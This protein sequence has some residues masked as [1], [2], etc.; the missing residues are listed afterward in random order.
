MGQAWTA[1]DVTSTKGKQDENFPVGSWL[2]SKRNRSDVHAYYNFAR[3]SDDISDTSELTNEQKL[4]RLGSMAAI[5][6]GE[7]KAPQRYDAHTAEVLRDVLI[8]RSVP[9]ETATDLLHAFSMDVKKNRYATWEELLHYCQYS[10]NPVGRF[11]LLLHGENK[12]TLPASDALCTA[13]QVINHLQDA[14]KD[15]KFLDR[16]YVPSSWMEEEGVT[17]DDLRL[18][19]SKPGIRRVFDRMLDEVDRLNRQASTLPMLIR[20]RHMRLEASVI[21]KLSCLLAQRLRQKDPIQ[22]RVALKKADGLKA[23]AY[24]LKYIPSR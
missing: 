3:A 22:E 6:R 20:N 19:R 2:I 11:L 14:A 8:K 10:A 7:E 4:D 12:E 23:L 13:L 9:I 1:K 24:A 17:I 18:V 15:L 16:C 21:V 5:M